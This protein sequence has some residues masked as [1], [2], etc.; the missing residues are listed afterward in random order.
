VENETKENH[1]TK[2]DFKNGR[3]MTD[4]LRQL[5]GMQYNSVTLVLIYYLV[6]VSV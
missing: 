3:R 4:K 2:V 5:D 6:L 1:L